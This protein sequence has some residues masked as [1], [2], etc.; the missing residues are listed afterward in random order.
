MLT[1]SVFAHILTVT[2]H[3]RISHDLNLVISSFQDFWR[4]LVTRN[5]SL[6]LITINTY[7]VLR[8]VSKLK[9]ILLIRN[10]CFNHFKLSQI[11]EYFVHIQFTLNFFFTLAVQSLHFSTDIIKAV[12]V[13]P[14]YH[15][16]FQVKPYIELNGKV[17]VALTL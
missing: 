4:L 16:Q 7:S 6:W 14:V 10:L 1:F 9:P 15:K 8:V 3:R 12:F 5:T 2:F 17:C 11:I 13:K